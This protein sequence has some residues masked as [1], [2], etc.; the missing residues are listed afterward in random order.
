MNLNPIARPLVLTAVC[1]TCALFSNVAQ[2]QLMVDMELNKKSYVDHEP[3]TATIRVKNIAGHDLILSGPNGGGWL[4]F[5]VRRGNNGLSLRPDAPTIRPHALKAGATHTTT[6][7]LGRYYPLG[8]PSNYAITASVYYAPLKR[9]FSST[10]Q[11]VNVLKA[12][13]LWFQSF[14]VPQGNNRPVQFRKYSLLSF[15]DR[16]S[17]ELYIRVASED[18]GV[19]Y[20]TYSIG[21]VL[22]SF[23]PNVDVDSANRLNVLHLGGPQFYAHTIVDTDGTLVRQDYYKEAGGS[24]PELKNQGGSIVVRGGVK[25]DRHG[26]AGTPQ[27]SPGQEK[28]NRVRGGNERPE[29]LP[30]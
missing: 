26:I 15:R 5:D 13:S 1:L 14:G 6:V 29:G 3:I 7:N 27:A 24:R 30:R 8:L 4:N 18:G 21:R 20:A 2:A 22:R 10:R 12:K 19:V 17:S 28:V 23:E 16:N 25:T 9:Y 11:L